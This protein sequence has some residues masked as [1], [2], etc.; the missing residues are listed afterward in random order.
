[1]VQQ[2]NGYR[3][4]AYSW[5]AK[6]RLV[7][8]WVCR[9]GKR[10]YRKKPVNREMVT[11]KEW[12]RASLV[13]LAR[14]TADKE[15]RRASLVGLVRHTADLDAVPAGRPPRCVRRALRVSQRKHKHD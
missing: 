14:H 6:I 9:L 3:V 12:Q 7:W 4:T 8:Q 15:W 11:G 5:T 1:M 13:G 10:K 2:P